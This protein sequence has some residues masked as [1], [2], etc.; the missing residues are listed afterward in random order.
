MRR[1]RW[2]RTLGSLSAV[3]LLSFTV[4]TVVALGIITAYGLI[5]AIL[6]AFARH[7]RPVVAPAPALVP[8]HTH[9]GD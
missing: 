2:D 7:S 8:S 9:A 3:L 5:T 6:F 1:L 4:V